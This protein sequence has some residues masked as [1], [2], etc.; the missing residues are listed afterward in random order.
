M[1]TSKSPSRL[2]RLISMNR[3]EVAERLQQYLLARFDFLRYRGRHDLREIAGSAS[4]GDARGRFFFDS[5]ELLDIC[6]LIKRELPAQSEEIIRRANQVC[7]HHFD[8]LGY[9]NL[10]YGA[11]IDWHLDAV[12]GKRA[13]KSPWY[14]IRY[15]D[16]EQ[17]GDAKITWEL[18]RH[19]HFVTLAKAYL[20]TGDQAFASE[21]ISQW[22]HWWKENPYPVGLNWASSLE[23][24]LRTQSWI[25]TLFLLRTCPLFTEELR[26]RWIAGL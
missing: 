19:Q 21:V 1:A 24:G 17:V 11:N 4:V 15:L 7:G 8:L 26:R 14:K 9:E 16:F 23:V 20:L 5:E 10:D 2:K 25:W 12:H 13:P 18:N 3:A 22:E 6:G